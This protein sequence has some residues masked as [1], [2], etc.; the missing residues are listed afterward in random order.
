MQI[1]EI[2]SSLTKWGKNYRENDEKTHHYS[3]QHLF[4]CEVAEK[5]SYHAVFDVF[6]TKLI[7]SAAPNEDAKEFDYRKKNYKQVTKPYWDK[8]LAAT[9][10][11][12]NKQ[13]YTIEWKDEEVK[14]FFTYSY[15]VHGDYEQWFIDNVHP[16]KFADPNAVLAIKP[17][18]IP[19]EE[20]EGEFI[21]NQTE[22]ITPMAILY[23]GPDVFIYKDEMTLIR[24]QE[25]SWVKFSGR[26]QMTGLIFELYD[27]TTIY[28]IIQVGDKV[29]YTFEVVEFY[30][31]G[32]E[33][34]PAWCLKGIPKPDPEEILYYSHFQ[35]ALPSLDEAAVLNST[36]F[37]VTNK[38]AFP[39]RWYY[40][41]SCDVC[42]G[43][44]RIE[45]YET[46][47]SE[48]C[49]ACGGDGKK[50]T[51]TWGKDFVI[52][53][54]D[55]VTQTDTTTLPNPPF[56][57]EDGKVETIKYLGEE[58]KDLCANAFMNLNI[59]ITNKATGVTATEIED[60]KDELISFLI[61]ISRE[62]FY[63]Q[64]ES[65]DAHTWMRWAKEEVVEVK[66]P[67]EFRVRSSADIT[68]EIK[69][70]KEA[71]LPLPYQYKLL[72]EGI[73]QRFKNDSVIDDV[74]RV[75]NVIDPMMGMD[76]N[77]VNQLGNTGVV[78]KWRVTLHY[79]IFN[80]ITSEL[81]KNP[82]FLEQE[83][84]TIK[85]VLEAA[86]KAMTPTTTNKAADILT[87]IQR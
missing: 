1:E 8:A 10:R 51:W 87:S 41:D 62:E 81:E 64:Q 22:P 2:V 45:N 55:N 9:N 47:L 26:M 18:F 21:V 48:R 50:M 5:L 3:D 42:Q 79:F 7:N 44:G 59:Y 32:W 83:I 72:Q 74:L 33:Q 77:A 76:D 14:E 43:T 67:N 13:N 52:P 23:P 37:A 12:Y 39:T 15:P 70:A 17:Q 11:I 25:K 6:P 58:T 63:L 20:I 19:G 4:R 34:K 27:S 61:K 82:N 69:L 56:G 78:D 54:P 73:Q 65:I 85:G 46:N 30:E 29:D 71:K 38:V 31:H 75:V 28:R 53:M 49:T 86:A 35:C 16:M 36:R 80:L 24:T 60:D 66:E 57:T 68:E 40:E 84:E